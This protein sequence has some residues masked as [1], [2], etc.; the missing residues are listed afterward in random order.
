M[1]ADIP[2]FGNFVFQFLIIIPEMTGKRVEKCNGIAF[3][4]LYQNHKIQN[5]KIHNYDTSK[6]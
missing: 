6:F 4:T 3:E 1:S 2:H 5:K